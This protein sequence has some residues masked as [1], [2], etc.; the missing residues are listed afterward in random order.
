MNLPEIKKNFPSTF[1]MLMAKQKLYAELL[2]LP[3]SDLSDSDIDLMY[4]LSKDPEM[5]KIWDKT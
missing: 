1:N 4:T 3:N 5:Q 2:K